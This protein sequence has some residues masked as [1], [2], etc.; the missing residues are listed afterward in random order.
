MGANA[1]EIGRIVKANSGVISRR[2]HP[3]LAEACS[4]M[5]RK[6]DLMPVLPGVYAPTASAANPFVRIRAVMEW[7]PDA[8]LTGAA[9]ARV[10]F[11][12]R[13]PMREVD[14][15]LPKERRGRY[16]GFRFCTRSIPEEL[17]VTRRLLR[18]TTAALTALDLVSDVGADGIDTALR[19]R[20]A[21]LDGMR[22]ALELTRHRSGNKER[23][24]LLLDSR[25]EPWSAAERLAH[26]LFREAGLTGWRANWAVPSLGSV[27]YIDIAFPTEML[28]IEIDGRIHGTEGDVFE[29]D[30]W[31]QN[32]LALR[33]WRVLRFTWRMLTEHPELVIQAVRQA[34]DPNRSVQ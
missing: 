34:L 8:V 11:W 19:T 13:G 5:V 4:W 7:A 18:F 2:Q 21:T 14:V 24:Q 9:A 22:G 6:G 33:G 12:P 31:R 26:R 16:R 28:A 30:R 32:H 10:S 27:Y 29:S 1:E 25:D 23:R 3:E 20:A 15:A 17:I